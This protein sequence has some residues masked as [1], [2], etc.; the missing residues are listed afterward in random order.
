MKLFKMI[1]LKLGG[2]FYSDIAI[3][4]GYQNHT[5]AINRLHMIEVTKVPMSESYSFLVYI[6]FVDK[7]F[8]MHYV[9]IQSFRIYDFVDKTKLYKKLYRYLQELVLKE[10]L[11]DEKWTK[12]PQSD[13]MPNLFKK[14]CVDYLYDNFLKH[15]LSAIGSWE[16]CK[17]LKELH[18]DKSITTKELLE[19]LMRFRDM[20]LNLGD[21][22]QYSSVKRLISKVKL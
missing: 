2:K 8:Y 16:A 3:K 19:Y 17:L 4:L 20:H 13:N 10:V 6:E 14:S 1:K 7:S 21:M 22:R 5:T 9:S 18:A 15:G 11:E 12:I